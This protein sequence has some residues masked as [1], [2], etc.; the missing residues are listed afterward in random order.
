ML[1]VSQ[2]KHDLSRPGR[3]KGAHLFLGPDLVLGEEA[4]EFLPDGRVGKIDPAAFSDPLQ[5]F[6]VLE[7]EGNFVAK[8]RN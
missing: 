3:S 1:Q 6:H 8:F 4:P 7:E 2:E 5:S